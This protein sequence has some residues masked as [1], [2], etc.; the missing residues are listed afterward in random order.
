MKETRRGGRTHP[1]ASSS[2]LCPD[3]HPRPLPKHLPAC[4]FQNLSCSEVWHL[5]SIPLMAQGTG[6]T[7]HS[8]LWLE[9]ARLGVQSRPWG[10]QRDPPADHPHPWGPLAG[11]GSRGAVP[12]VPRAYAPESWTHQ[13]LG[14][15]LEGPSQAKLP[16]AHPQAPTAPQ[17]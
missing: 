9:R 7:G 17:E 8:F 5:P 4:P 3:T 11:L 15:S 14:L 6:V 10:L 12:R 16:V 1:H 2:G 13:L